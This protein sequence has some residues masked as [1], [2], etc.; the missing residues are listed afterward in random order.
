MTSP[1]TLTLGAA[2]AS[3]IIN[4]AGVCPTGSPFAAQL[5]E[6]TSRLM[7]YGD[8][9]AT[10][11]KARVCVQRNCI[12][13]P[14]WVGT[15]LAVNLCNHTRPIQNGWFEFMPVSRADCLCGGRYQSNVTLVDDGLTPVFA[16]VP[17]GSANKV[18]A[19]PRYQAD[20]GKTIT[21][22]G[23]DEN[24]QEVMTQDLVTG[25]WAPGEIL[26]LAAG[27]TLSTKSYREVTRVTKEVT[28]GPVD[29]Y[30]YDVSLV[31]PGDPTHQGLLDMAHYDPGETNPMYR[32][33]TFRGGLCRTGCC[34]SNG[35]TQRKVELLAKLQFIPVVA[36]SDVVQI[37][38]IPALKLMIQAIR[39]EEAG[40]D[41]EAGK[42]QLLAIKE[43]NRQLRNKLPLDQIPIEVS[44]SG[45]ALPAH[46]GIGQ[47]L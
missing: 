10:V 20:V 3:S 43:L 12:T 21:L 4:I 6:A 19:Y 42:K 38:N 23:I 13:W 1:S 30:Q 34:S 39:L 29:V 27:G 41:D 47:L 31:V 22:Y 37:D 24:G 35:T 32:H 33:S 15:V 2:R 14:R 16:N 36:D 9:W 45:T 18:K 7:D 25:V 5:N 44:G 28:S 8:W 11:V 46:H 17:C 40:N 26:T